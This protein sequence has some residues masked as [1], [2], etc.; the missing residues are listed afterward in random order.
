MSR[1]STW[2][3]EGT[4]CLL[5]IWVRY[6]IDIPSPLCS[7]LSHDSFSPDG[8]TKT[9][10]KYAG[11]H[12][13]M[14]MHLTLRVRLDIQ[15][16]LLSPALPPLFYLTLYPAQDFF[17]QWFNNLCIHVGLFTNDGTVEKI[18]IW[19]GTSPNQKINIVLCI[20]MH[21]RESCS[22][23]SEKI[24]QTREWPMVASI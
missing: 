10:K 20:N 23:L 9:R 16:C 8:P 11:K 2:S 19:K 22:W 21:Y 3:K 15:D 7:M 17:V 1:G 18:S 12:I 24:T 6:P 13:K 14:L 5:D 4:E